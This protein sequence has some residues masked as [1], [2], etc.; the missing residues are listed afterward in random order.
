MLTLISIE[1]RL[2]VRAGNIEAGLGLHDGQAVAL[3]PLTV[4]GEIV[5]QGRWTLG[6]AQDDPDGIAEALTDL[7][8]EMTRSAHAA[9]T[10]ARLRVPA[11]L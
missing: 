1:D 8:A 11:D 5:A 6:V 9:R 7:C 2:F 3:G 4:D 10:S